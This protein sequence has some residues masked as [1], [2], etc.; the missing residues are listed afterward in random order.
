[1]TASQTQ[2]MTGSAVAGQSETV[3]QTN[4][5]SGT[6]RPTTLATTRFTIDF[7]NYTFNLNS[8]QPQVSIGAVDS[9]ND[10]LGTARSTAVMF[11]TPF[12]NGEDYTP[13]RCDVLLHKVGGQSR[14]L[15]TDLFLTL[16]SDDNTDEHNPAMQVSQSLLG[17]LS[18]G[19]RTT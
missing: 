12:G 5:P 14:D 8:D 15:I 10:G 19:V 2:S 11:Q 16:Y 17:L 3:T 18:R 1:M 7:N 13:L 4:T 9:F 6:P